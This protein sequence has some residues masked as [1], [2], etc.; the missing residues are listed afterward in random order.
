MA[1]SIADLYTL[2]HYTECMKGMLVLVP[3]GRYA[4]KSVATDQERNSICAYAVFSG[5]RQRRA[6]A[7]GC[8]GHLPNVGARDT[9]ARDRQHTYHHL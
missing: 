8:S 1:G 5:T 9:S 4:V 7:V 6:P 2:E 3:Y